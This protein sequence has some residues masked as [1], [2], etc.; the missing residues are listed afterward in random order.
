MQRSFFF[1]IFSQATITIN[2]KTLV[3]PDRNVITYRYLLPYLLTPLTSSPSQLLLC[4]LSE[5]ISPSLAFPIHEFVHRVPFYDWLLSSN[6][7]WRFILCCSLCQDI[8]ILLNY[9]LYGMA[10]SHFIFP[11]TSWW[12]SGLFSFRGIINKISVNMCANFCVDLSFQFSQWAPWS[13]T[14]G[15]Y[16]TL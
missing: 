1:S 10:I 3:T 2:F 4:F 6:T 9:I 14:T 7:F 11:F 15:S 13:L 8:F 5:W 16:V 12:T